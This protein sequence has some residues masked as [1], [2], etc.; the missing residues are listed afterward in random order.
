M[1]ASVLAI[2]LPWLTCTRRGSPV[3]PEVAISAASSSSPQLAAGV[4]PGPEGRGLP[5]SCVSP[6]REAQSPGVPRS[7]HCARARVLRTSAS[8]EPASAVSFTGTATNP[9]NIAPRYARLLSGRRLQPIRTRSPRCNPAAVKLAA[10]SAM[11][12][13]SSAAAQRSPLCA[14]SSSEPRP[15]RSTRRAAK[16]HSAERLISC[17]DFSEPAKLPL[18]EAHDLAH[19][20]HLHQLIDVE[21][22]VELLLEAAG[23]CDVAH[24][25]PCFDVS[26][27]SI[28]A[29]RG[30]V[31]IEGRT[32]S[33]A[34][35]V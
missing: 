27:D 24:R 2:R 20:L 17:C 3:D 28:D 7:V 10:K 35:S 32:E 5:S 4:A 16:L 6:Q 29:D 19:V 9:P 11:R 23:E 26:G 14:S 18:Q 1:I 12:V 25:V 31:H 22:Q 33:L 8:P 34:Y 21:S 13:G 15:R 30:R